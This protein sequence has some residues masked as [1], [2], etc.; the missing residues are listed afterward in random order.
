MTVAKCLLGVLAAVSTGC[1]VARAGGAASAGS[2]G[3]ATAALLAQFK[4]ATGGA[5]WDEVTALELKGTLSAGGLEGPIRIL[6]D[7]RT[8]RSTSRYTLGPVQGAEGFDGKTAWQQDPGSELTTL[9]APEALQGVRTQAWLTALGYWY[10]ARWAATLAAPEERGDGGRHYR[11]VV[12]TP[13]GGHPVAL[14]F[15]TATG[16]LARTVD[17]QGADTVTTAL[18]DYREARPA[19]DRNGARPDRLVRV[20]FHIVIDRTDPSGRTDPRA[21]SEVRLSAGTLNVPLADADFSL[22][23]MAPTASVANAAG[24]TRIPF[25]LI[26]NHIYVSA[27]LGGAAVRMLVDTGGVNLLTPAAAKRLGLAVEG[28]LAGGGVGAEKV[29]VGLAHASELRLGDAVLEKPSLYVLDLG[30]IAAIEGTGTDG[31]VGFELFRRFRVTIDYAA[32][33]LTLSTKDGFRPPAGAHAVPFE[34]ADRIPIVRGT[35]DGMPV[36]VSIDTGSRVSLTLH[37][38]FV[39][40]HGLVDRY[41][42]A[43]ERVVGWGVGGPALGRPARLGALTLGDLT[44]RDLAGDLFLDNTGAFANPDL[45]G[46]LGGGVLR[47]F[48]VAFDYDGRQMYLLPNGPLDAADPFDRSGLWLLGD[49]SAVRIAAVA[50]GSAGEK[51]G[52]KKDDR[53]AA[54]D[55]E[56]VARRPLADWRR[57]L[58]EQ[59]AG[60]RVVL[61]VAQAAGTRKA[62]L[63]LADAIPDHARL[64]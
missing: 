11:V 53:I 57:Y 46:N 61:S 24:V 58:R 28:K 6:Q 3:G 25:E 52:L 63:I 47:R 36:R 9:D 38:P 30:P 18:D 37:S 31:I 2:G 32:G 34:M 10:P 60:T 59:P 19:D 33:V 15:D 51:A 50:P 43:P 17:R 26:N 41:G 48:T 54:V 49:E 4:A 27:R 13:A 44:L 29:D 16:L 20:P 42:A 62:E 40:E 21:R 35:L 23:E 45:S 64:H 7:A 39:K 55:G 8:G 1:A 12:V 56:P 5:A 14:W 22:P